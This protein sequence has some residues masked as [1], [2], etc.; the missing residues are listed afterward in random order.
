MFTEKPLS[1][2]PDKSS[3]NLSNLFS[4]NKSVRVG[5]LF[6]YTN[7]FASI[8][9]ASP[10]SRINISWNFPSHHLINNLLNWKRYHSQGGGV[11]RFYGIHFISVFAQLG[12]TDILKSI[13][14]CSS[15]DEFIDWEFS[16]VLKSGIFIDLTSQL[17]HQCQHLISIQ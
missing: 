9:R 2:N 17:L 11:L 10:G 5:Y 6:L 13:L 4:F 8:L 12:I 3:S 16:C 1:I 15:T 7:W 14:Y